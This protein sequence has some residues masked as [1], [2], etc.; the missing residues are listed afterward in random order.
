M[1][2]K[3]YYQTLGV[4]RSAGAEEIKRAYRKLAR[5][6]HPDVSK[7]IDAEDRFKD[8]QEAYEVLG[9]PEKRA[10]YDQLGSRWREGDSFEPPPGWQ[11]GFRSRAAGEG[12]S[13]FFRDIFGGDFEGDFSGGFGGFRHSQQTTL[14]LT[15]EE[16]AR[17]GRH[18]IHVRSLQPGKGGQLH[19]V[20]KALDIEVPAGVTEGEQLHV[21]AEEGLEL[22]VTIRLAPHPRFRVDGY[23]LHVDVEVSPWVAAL[24][25]KIR[26][27]TLQREVS[28]TVPPGTRNG[29]RLRLRGKGL[30][31]GR[32]SGDLYAVVRVSA[33]P[34]S[35]ERQRQ[36]YQALAEAFGEAKGV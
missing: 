3:D 10:A 7:E 2:Y 15:L 24:G 14:A 32:R 16:A 4:D 29:Q 5:K 33:P 35:N 28:M 1:E 8:V 17:G 26:V 12:F 11:G 25:G 30:G 27:P 19:S 23:N 9:D 36:A 22:I 6:Y 18:R 21:Q 13:S 20:E 34:A 31:G